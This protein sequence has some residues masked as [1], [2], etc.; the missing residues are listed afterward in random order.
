MSLGSELTRLPY[1]E[2]WIC[3]G[4][5]TLSKSVVHLAMN[6]LLRFNTSCTQLFSKFAISH[7]HSELVSSVCQI[8][9]PGD[10]GSKMLTV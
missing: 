7:V 1:D 10:P 6:Q 9:P 5:F 3:Q 4:I 8:G 2:I